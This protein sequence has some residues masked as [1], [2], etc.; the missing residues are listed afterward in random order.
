MVYYA[1]RLLP[2]IK[3]VRTFTKSKAIG[4]PPWMSL[5]S[6]EKYKKI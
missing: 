3:N 2:S 5:T 4:E 6:S 1:L